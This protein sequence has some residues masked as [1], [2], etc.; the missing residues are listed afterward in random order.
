M[1]RWLRGCSKQGKD[2][3]SVS[4]E[5]PTKNITH[6]PNLR[7]PKPLHYSTI[8]HLVQEQCSKTN[9]LFQEANASVKGSP[10]IGI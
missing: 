2:G 6:Q 10:T 7:H 4:E 5:Q 3:K 8:Q 1:W 9:T